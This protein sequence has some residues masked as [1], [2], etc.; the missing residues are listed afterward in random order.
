MVFKLGKNVPQ[1]TK[2]DSQTPGTE[3]LKV[4]GRGSILIQYSICFNVK[5][6]VVKCYGIEG[7]NNIL[8]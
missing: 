1:G 4:R 2:F 3:G 8:R 6:N 7:H 5:K